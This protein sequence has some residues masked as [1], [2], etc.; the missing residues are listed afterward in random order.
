M[1]RI[2]RYYG[3]RTI[4][5]RTMPCAVCAKAQPRPC[6]EAPPSRL[7]RLAARDGWPTC[8]QVS[9]FLVRCNVAHPSA[10][11]RILPKFFDLLQIVLHPWIYRGARR[12]DERSHSL[13]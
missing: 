1:A 3:N 9:L 5:R 13:I 2:Y 8:K 4:E 6:V 10:L 12:A 7:G 11:G